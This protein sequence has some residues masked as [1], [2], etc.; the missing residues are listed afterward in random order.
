MKLRHYDENDIRLDSML[1]Q[2]KL[3]DGID[4]DALE[5]NDAIKT[6]K[7]TMPTDE[8]GFLHEAAI[9]GFKGVLY[10]SWY[11]CVKTEL[12]G[13]TPIRGAK[14]FDG[15]KTWTSPEIIAEDP[16]GKILFCPP[17][18]G[19]DDGKLY[20]LLNEMVSADHM[21][22]LDIFVLNESTGKFDFLRTM[23][24]PFKLNTNVYSMNNG[25]L[26]L[27]GRIAEPDGF[28]NTP[29]VLISDSG[30]IDSD[31][32]LVKIME[33]DDLPDGSH[34]VHPEISALID[35]ENLLIFCRDDLRRVPLVFISRDFGET[36]SAPIATDIPFSNSKIYS[37]TLSDGRNYVIGNRAPDR[38]R[39]M[40]LISQPGKWLFDKAIM[41]Q[42]G[43]GELGFGTAWHYPAA[44]ESDGKLFIIYTVETGNGQRGSVVS[45]VDTQMI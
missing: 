2:M 18:Y 24:I 43:V 41:L 12:Q 35:G 7:V 29:A 26:L 15:G 38:T 14:S 10:A 22:A 11:N 32:R 13:L 39:L 3:V 30:R 19:I 45:V 42:N 27:P 34:L 1:D 31:W 20:L 33:N 21:H 17:V 25:K 8:F 4:F 28:P 40:M 36:W 23:P 44:Y 16:T 5:K 9:I 37:G 6:Y